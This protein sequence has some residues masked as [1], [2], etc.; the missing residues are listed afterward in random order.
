MNMTISE[1]NINTNRNVVGPN[2][3][4]LFEF[5]YGMANPAYTDT[6]VTYTGNIS[7]GYVS[8]TLSN[9]T[10]QRAGVYQYIIYK[11]TS[12]DVI[13][14]EQYLIMAESPSTPVISGLSQHAVAG[15][16]Y[17]LNCSAVSRSE[18]PGHNLTMFSEWRKNGVN[19]MADTKYGVDGTILTIRNLSGTDNTASLTCIAFEDQRVKSPESMAFFLNVYYGPDNT[20][21]SP[22]GQL[23]VDEGRLLNITC[24]GECNPPCSSY[25]WYKDS[26]PT[27]LGTSQT[28]AITNVS[29]NSAGVY[30]CAVNNTY[31][32]KVGTAQT[33]V[34]VNYS[35]TVDIESR[36]G[37][38]NDTSLMIKCSAYGIPEQYTYRLIHKSLS[39]GIEIREVSYEFIS[40]G[41]IIHRFINPTYMDTGIY[42]C[43]VSNGVLDY[44]D[45][46]LDKSIYSTVWIKGLPSITSRETSFYAEVG[47]SGRLIIEVYNSLL[48]L[49]VTWYKHNGG[50]LE[51]LM[52]SDKYKIIIASSMV[53]VNFYSV[54]IEEPGFIA[55]LEIRNITEEDFSLYQVHVQNSVGGMYPVLL[56]LRVISKLF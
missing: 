30:F 19:I 13:A 21:I 41:V 40:T 35:P 45:G 44:T 36:N 16:E 2:N 28:L 14:G 50:A 17:K 11:G 22:S 51:K 1:R 8:F 54:P 31:I 32:T 49:V 4:I 27:L 47:H 52:N 3:F 9:L 12:G 34:R 46:S 18:K 56:Q 7:E 24:S 33:T 10:M 37:S 55:T 5:F 29:R 39:S 38:H 53:D 25:Q 48:D 26:Q 20:Q 42:T 6:D 43:F 23:T 15:R